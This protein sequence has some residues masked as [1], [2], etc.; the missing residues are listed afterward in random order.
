MELDMV[1][2]MEKREEKRF[3]AE[4]INGQEKRFLD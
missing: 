4:W 2:E 3:M 1:S